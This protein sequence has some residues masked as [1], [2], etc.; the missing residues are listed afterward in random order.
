MIKISKPY[1]HY[2]RCRQCILYEDLHSNW[3]RILYVTQGI[4]GVSHEP[5][6][7]F[8][9]LDLPTVMYPK[10]G[11]LFS[12]PHYSGSQQPF[13]KDIIHSNLSASI[14]LQIYKLLSY[15][16]KFFFFILL[17][18]YYYTLSHSITPVSWV[19]NSCT[20]FWP[21]Q[22]ALLF[23]DLNFIIN[24]YI[25]MTLSLLKTSKMSNRCN[26]LH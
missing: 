1:T 12:W 14:S 8:S 15:I 11:F 4:A 7:C 16:Q 10:T 6:T 18:L 26:P 5:N 13:Y 25:F 22:N 23:C 20:F 2:S 19:K 3:I 24:Y 9:L 21:H 17:T